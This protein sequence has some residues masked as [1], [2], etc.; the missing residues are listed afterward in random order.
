LLGLGLEHFDGVGGYRSRDNGGDIDASGELDGVPFSDHI[1]FAEVLAAN[2][3]FTDCLVIQMFRGA[4]GHAESPAHNASLNWLHDRFEDGGYRLKPALHELL[5]S[6]MFRKAGPLVPASPDPLPPLPV[7][8]PGPPADPVGQ[9][10][11]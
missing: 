3:E 8:A 2:E 9:G 7:A 6:P 11:P 10:Q 4:L 5:M 1:E